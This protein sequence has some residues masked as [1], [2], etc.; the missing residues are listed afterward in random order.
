[1]REKLFLFY[2]NQNK[3]SLKLENKFEYEKSI[4]MATIFNNNIG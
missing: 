3:S 4:V 1:M 2:E